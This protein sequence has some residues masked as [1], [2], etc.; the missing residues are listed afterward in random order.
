MSSFNRI[1]INIDFNSRPKGADPSKILER[2]E[3]IEKETQD[4]FKEEKL[5]R[6]SYNTDRG[7]SSSSY[8]PN[9]PLST[10]STMDDFETFRADV[11]LFSNTNIETFLNDAND[12]HSVS[13]ERVRFLSDNDAPSE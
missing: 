13:S 8:L 11:E 12:L 3:Q 4:R 1:E 7:A 6:Q 9:Q 5:N 10:M 2:L